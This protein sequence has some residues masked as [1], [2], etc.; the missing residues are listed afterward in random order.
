P[1]IATA[2]PSAGTIDLKAGTLT[3]GD[4]VM[5]LATGFDRPLTLT[6]PLTIALKPGVKTLTVTSGGSDTTRYNAT[7]SS[8]VE[9]LDADR[10]PLYIGA[11]D[12]YGLDATGTFETADLWLK[13]DRPDAEWFYGAAQPGT[14]LDVV[15]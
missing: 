4:R 1:S 3:V 15:G 7:I 11:V 13:L 6:E 9:L 5:K 12:S 8:A 10:R 14:V 2:L